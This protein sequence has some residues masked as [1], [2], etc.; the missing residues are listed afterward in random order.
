M[1]TVSAATAN[2]PF[3]SLLREVSSGEVVTVLSRGKPVATMAP[4]RRT[5]P[6][7]AAA[8]RALLERLERVARETGLT[9]TALARE[10][11]REHL[12]DLEDLLLAQARARRHRET[13]PLDDVERQLG[14]RRIYPSRS[15]T[16]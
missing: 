12:D 13:L 1:K 2:R 14:L 9:K 6:G 3:S 4:V 7:R 10:A 16:V 15:G 8:R 5:N 11:I